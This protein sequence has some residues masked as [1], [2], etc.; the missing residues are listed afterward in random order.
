MIYEILNAENLVFKK[1]IIKYEI[2]TIDIV[3]VKNKQ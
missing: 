1:E 2:E 3:K